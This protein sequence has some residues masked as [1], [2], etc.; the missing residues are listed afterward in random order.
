MARLPINSSPLIVSDVRSSIV[1]LAR[2]ALPPLRHGTAA[3]CS[4]ATEHC[5][6]NKGSH[7]LA[8]YSYD[9]S[10]KGGSALPDL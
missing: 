4:Y 8:N 1:W 10:Q 6:K 7:S 5:T 9:G 2:A 3:S